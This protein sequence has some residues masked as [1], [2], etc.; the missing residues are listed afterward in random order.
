MKR[1]PKRDISKLVSALRSVSGV[2]AAIV[3][4][5]IAR[6]DYGPSS[7]IDVLVIVDAPD[8]LEAVQ[9]II[10]GLEL[11]RL[12]QPL[13][14]TREQLQDVDAGLMR[15]VFREGQVLFSRMPFSI[16]AAGILD[17]HPWVLY[18]FKLKDLP[19]NEKARFNRRLYSSA[20][21]ESGGGVLGEVGGK[22]LARG[23]VMVPTA[24]QKQ[25]D[26]LF[27]RFKVKPEKINIWV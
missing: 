19:Q 9:E 22:Q 16:P 27:R 6:G 1:F 7:D 8:S 23:C 2:D 25:M 10:A 21:S 18:T 4:G 15:N 26:T 20:K 11:N 13:F 12:G 5:S 24:T 17:V 14:R 3:Y